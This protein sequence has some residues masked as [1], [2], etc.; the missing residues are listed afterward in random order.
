MGKST[1]KGIWAREQWLG[2]SLLAAVWVVDD[3]PTVAG[4]LVEALSMDGHDVT[5]I[6]NGITAWQRLR[7]GELPDVILADLML[8][9]LSGKDLSV[10]IKRDETLSQIPV[11]LVTGMEFDQ[12]EFP[13]RD[14]YHAV[15]RKPF[16][17]MEVMAAVAR[18]AQDK[19]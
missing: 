19:T 12:T 7:Q 16:D 2:G 5:H 10:A 8:S 9:G 4:V 15:I 17:L 6:D 1:E 3:E 14:A 18:L 11:L 13:P